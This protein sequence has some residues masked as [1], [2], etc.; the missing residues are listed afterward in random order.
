MDYTLH[1][2]GRAS[3]EFMVDL[4]IRCEFDVPD[5]AY[6]V[7]ELQEEALTGKSWFLKYQPEFNNL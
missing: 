5:K 7:T 4:G 6:M 1:Q 2:R 3:M